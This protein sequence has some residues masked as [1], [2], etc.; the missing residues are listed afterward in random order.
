MNTL[1]YTTT[2]TTLRYTTLITLHYTKKRSTTL[3]YTT[4]HY[5]TL[6]Y[7]TLHYTALHCTT[8]HY[9]NYNYNHTTLPYTTQ[10]YTT[11]HSATLHS[12]TLQNTTLHYTTLITLHYAP[13]HYTTLHCTTLRYTALHCTTLLYTNYNYNYNFNYKYSYTTLHHTTPHYTTP[14]YT[15]LTTTT[16][17]TTTTLL[18]TRLHYTT[19]HYTTLHSYT[20]LHYTTLHAL[21]HHKRNCNYTTLITLHHNYESTTLQLQLQLHYTT[22]HPR[23]SVFNTFDFEMCFAPQRC[24][25]FFHI[26]TSKSG[27]IGNVLRATTACNFFISHLT[28]CLRTRRFSEPTFRPSGATNHLEKHSESRLFYLFARLHFLSSDSFPSLIFSLL[29]LSSL[30]LPTSAFP[31]VHIVGSLTSKL[32]PVIYLSPFRSDSY[33]QLFN[34]FQHEHGNWAVGGWLPAQEVCQSR[35]GGSNAASK[36]NLSGVNLRNVDASDKTRVKTQSQ[37]WFTGILQDTATFDSQ[38]DGFLWSFPLQSIDPE[39]RKTEPRWGVTAGGFHL[40]EDQG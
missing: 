19:L 17:A 2:T 40:E 10:H 35:S 13:L 11:L 3:R 32:P 25:P 15:T 14:H 23:P 18:Y 39:P 1:H 24:A 12:T 5:A 7:T 6:R 38:I 22:L 33:F 4:L 29:F 27:A 16:A 30:T 28:R 21:D 34:Y 9:T 37:N 26:S 36:R 31:S 20:R 8:L